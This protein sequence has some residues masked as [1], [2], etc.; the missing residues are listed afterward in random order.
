MRRC[1]NTRQMAEFRTTGSGNQLQ[2]FFHETNI[3]GVIE[4]RLEPHSDDR[5]F[6]ARFWCQDEFEARPFVDHIFKS[7][8]TPRLSDFAGAF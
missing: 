1:L 5:G 8:L 2:M 4:I 6:F 3:Q 7:R